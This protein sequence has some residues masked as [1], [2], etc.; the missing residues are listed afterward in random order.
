MTS[1]LKVSDFTVVASG[2]SYPEGPFWQPDNTLLVC[3]VGNGQ[4]R[5][6]HLDNGAIDVVASLGGGA[7]GCAVGPD[8]AIYVCNNGGMLVL[9]ATQS[10]GGKIT[11]ALGE[12]TANYAGGKIQRVDASG[13]FKD[14]YTQFT[15]AGQT[16]PVPLR[17]P[18]DITFDSSGGFWFTDFGKM[19]GR[20]EDL[21]G[22]YYAKPDGSSI[23]E[24]AFPRRAPNGIAL[25]PDEKRLYVSESFTRRIIYYELSGPGQIVPNPNT[26]MDT[27]YLLTAAIPFQ[28]GL[29]SIRTDEEGNVYAAS[30][31]PQGNNMNTRGGITVVSPPQTPGGEGKILEYIE[32]DIGQMDPLPS[33]IC[34]GGPDRQTAFITLGGTGRVVSCRM[35][36]PGKK[37]AFE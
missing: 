19:N 34:F 7:N 26:M 33:N 18:D 10:N 12:I 25:S 37:P 8:G 23:K 13:K 17:N 15:P 28:A 11:L 21:T 31:A 2:L 4:L 29:D 1:N 22:I 32:I 6:V 35:R 5:R 24:M 3:E 20:T 36:I 27:S 9:S 14:L 16:T 30:F